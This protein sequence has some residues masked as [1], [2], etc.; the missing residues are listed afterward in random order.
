MTKTM[1]R[2]VTPVESQ[3]FFNI[4]LARTYKTTVATIKAKSPREKEN[5][6]IKAKHTTIEGPKSPNIRNK[7]IEAMIAPN[8][9]QKNDQRF[10]MVTYSDRNLSLAAKK[11][12]RKIMIR[13]LTISLG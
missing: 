11:P 5:K 10:F 8:A 3:I 9:I 12:A 13:N 4:Q 2:T 1:I 7:R 6:M